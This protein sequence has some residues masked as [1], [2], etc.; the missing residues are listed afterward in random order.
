MDHESNHHKT[1]AGIAVI[2]ICLIAAIVLLRHGTA[3]DVGHSASSPRTGERTAYAPSPL[4]AR[5]P[6][7]AAPSAPAPARLVPP[8]PAPARLVSPAPALARSP[9]P[10][11]Q[12]AAARPGLA[13]LPRP[14]PRPP[15]PGS[16]PPRPLPQAGPTTASRTAPPAA[17]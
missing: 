10:M 3:A 14:L 12:P 1:I 9:Q 11:I 13:P 17:L 2:A 15:V 5:G 7:P 16:L 8:A 4:T 6:A